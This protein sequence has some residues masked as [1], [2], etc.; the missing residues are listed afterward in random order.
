VQYATSDGTATAGADYTPKS[1]TLTFAAGQTSK[2]FSVPLLNDTTVEGNETVTLTLT[3]PGGGAVLGTP[4][5]AVLTITENDLGGVLQFSAAAYSVGEGL[6]GGQAT[7]TVTRTGGAASG[8]T[9]QYATGGGTA[10]AGVDYA[11]ASGTLTFAAGQTSQ[12]FKVS[13]LNDTAVE[14]SETIGLTL[15]NPGGG[16]TLGA[17]STAVLTITENDLGGVLQFSAAAYSVGET[18][19]QATI[20]VTRTGGAA[21]GVTAQYATGGGTATAGVDYAPASG[22]LTFAAG[23]TS[24][25]FTVPILD[26]TLAE[27]NETVGLTLVSPGGGATLG[28]R[29]TAVLTLVDDD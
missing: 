6:A 8:V 17:R 20:T 27:G 7:I 11:P 22:T 25:T 18:G 4:S 14:G 1:D 29:R 19:G 21:S 15:T 26:D 9:V 2:T 23:Q 24:Q 12:T 28:A 10:T 3:A 5:T 13:L 16:A